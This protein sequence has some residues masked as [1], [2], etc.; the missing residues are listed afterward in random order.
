MQTTTIVQVQQIDVSTLLSNIDGLIENRLKSFIPQTST[1]SD[2]EEF[3]TREEVAKLFKISLPT[4]HDW[5]NKGLLKS[6]RIGNKVRYRKC[7]VLASP[8]ATHE[9]GVKV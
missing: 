3:L 2:A 6:Y 8:K 4:L 9:E 5:T 7:E 1:Q